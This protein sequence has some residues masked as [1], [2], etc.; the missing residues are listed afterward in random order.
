MQYYRIQ[1]TFPKRI[2]TCDE[3]IA[4]DDRNERVAQIKAAT[5]EYNEKQGEHFCFVP[6]INQNGVTVG[7][8]TTKQMDPV[9]T[10]KRFIESIGLRTKE[11]RAEEITFS[12]LQSALRQ[13]DRQD[14]IQDDDEVL[15][16]FGLEAL[17]RSMRFGENLAREKCTQ[18]ELAELTQKQLAEETLTPELARI[19]AGKNKY[20]ALGHPVHYLVETDNHDT[21]REL[22]RI[23]LDALYACG[24]ME[25]RRYA[26]VDFRP[27]ENYSLMGYETLYKSSV[28]G[29]VL[30]RYLGGDQVEEEN[31]SDENRIIEH[32]CRM[33][34]TYRNS[35]LTVVCL[36]RACKRIKAQLYEGMDT[37]S[38]V[39]VREDLLSCERA[40][41]Q[42]RSLAKEH[43]VR[44][45]KKLLATLEAGRSYL[46]TELKPIFDEWYNTKLKTSV[47][48]Q[49]KDIGTACKTAAE[50][51]PR[52][53]AYDEL[54]EM[55]GLAD[56]KAVM[57]KA[58]NYYKMQQLYAQK[59]V[60]R[61]TPAMHM[62]FTG[63][64]GTAKTT[65]ARLFARIM[66]ENGL[67]PKGHLVE[68]GRGDLVGKFVGWTAQTVQAKFKEA[69]GGVLFIDEAY[70]LVDDR[71]G[72]YG[73]EA[74]NTIVQEM[75]NY[76]SELVV[77]FAGY[78]QQMEDFLAK[79]PG[80]RSRVAF[81]VPFADYSSEELCGITRLITEKNGMKIEQAALEKLAAVYESARTRSDFGNGRYVRNIFEQAKMNQA[82]R[83]M[84]KDF[85]SITTED[86]VTITADDIVT[87][88]AA[89]KTEK[90]RVGFF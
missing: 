19:Y 51:K 33:A 3:E 24:R 40:E 1:G 61:N 4:W 82:S 88:E 87:P 55:I 90:R 50:A 80:L 78:P 85:D 34:R 42:L 81:H 20:R 62:V 36:P 54:T 25:N 7:M 13:A 43:H 17:G 41:A 9:K 58:L 89:P 6:S 79:N 48:P 30:V 10:A 22:C 63:N 73:D 21:R 38:F 28:G 2:E 8:I 26:F 84:E 86:V 64:P 68:V 67:L 16:M 46:A 45:D 60:K 52:G 57:K 65:A 18:E 53:T 27:G 37:M 76:R 66:R 59:G 49:Y 47:Y 23:L 70:S 14:Y 72:S 11:L 69:V 5:E 56:A 35:V 44:V 15:G 77:I 83:L 75:E 12:T 31:A 71:G 32:I 29:A 39:E 74:I